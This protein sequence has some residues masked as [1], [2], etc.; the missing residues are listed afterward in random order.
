MPN[1][2]NLPEVI[3]I[4]NEGLRGIKFKDFEIFIRKHFG[5]ITTKIIRVKENIVKTNGLIFDPIKTKKAFDK[6][7]FKNKKACHIIITDRIFATYDDDRRL[8][9]RASI[10]SF[11]SVISISGIV[12]GPAK[13]KE[14]YIYKD[15]FTSLGVWE[16]E[17]YKIKKKL[18]RRFIDYKDKR[19]GKVLKGY[20][21]QAIF[22]HI[23]GEPFCSQRGCRLFNSH[24]QEDLIY[25]QIKNARFCPAHDRFLKRVRA[26]YNRKNT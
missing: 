2:F 3:Y 21:S 12:E 1:N 14:Y 7:A 25:S 5:K 19:I 17:Q 20:I 10:Y 8:H 15:R 23:T 22:F 16:I 6:I 26:K 18:Q 13:P 11:P 24:W 9:I 4:Y